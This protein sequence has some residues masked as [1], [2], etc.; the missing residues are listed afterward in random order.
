MGPVIAA[1]TMQFS[2]LMHAADTDYNTLNTCL[3]VD[4][5]VSSEL[6]G[7]KLVVFEVLAQLQLVDFASCCVW[8]L[9]NKHDIFWDPPLGYLAL[10]Q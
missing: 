6:A 1:V 3:A 10:Q 2:R 5:I 9:L 4:P 7:R 8:D